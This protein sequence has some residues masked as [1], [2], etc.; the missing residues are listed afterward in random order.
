MHSAE[1]ICIPMAHLALDQPG[2]GVGED[3]YTNQAAWGL[4]VAS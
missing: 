3:V 4:V 1:A 2:L